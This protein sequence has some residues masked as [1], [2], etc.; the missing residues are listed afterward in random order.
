M[1]LEVARGYA[2]V[3]VRDSE[4]ANGPAL[5]FSTGGWSAFVTAVKQGEFSA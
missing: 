4:A 1:C 2:H 5:V 3:P